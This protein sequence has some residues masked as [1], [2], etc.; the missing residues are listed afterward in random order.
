MRTHGTHSCYTAG[1][2]RQECKEA[3]RVYERERK[4]FRNR[5]DTPWVKE[6]VVPAGP[7]RAK[8][9]YFYARGLNTMELAETI[10]FSHHTLGDIKNGK[11]KNCQRRV[12]QAVLHAPYGSARLARN[13]LVWLHE[14]GVK[15]RDVSRIT[16][17]PHYRLVAMVF[18]GTRKLITHYHEDMILSLGLYRF[19]KKPSDRKVKSTDGLRE[20]REEVRPDRD[21]VAVPLLQDEASLL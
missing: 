11:K 5:P 12:E 8:L 16:G 10:G 4:R 18:N 1:C 3:H 14:H 9:R 7:T 13:H 15:M 20:L 6:E 17:L 19:G 21:E 2:R